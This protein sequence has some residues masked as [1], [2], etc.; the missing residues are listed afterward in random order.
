[1]K[2]EFKVKS[3]DP[4]ECVLVNWRDGGSWNLDGSTRK[5]KDYGVIHDNDTKKTWWVDSLDKD[6]RYWSPRGLTYTS[7][8]GW[9]TDKPGL[10]SKGLYQMKFQICIYHDDDVPAT[11]TGDATTGGYITTK[12]IKCLD[13]E[14]SI[15]WKKSGI[16]HPAFW[17][18]LSGR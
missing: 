4:K 9:A 7:D 2:F 13:W 15:L 18:A 5:I 3:G 1:M 10:S 8:G 6:P 12:A 16:T 14:A 17:H 11:V